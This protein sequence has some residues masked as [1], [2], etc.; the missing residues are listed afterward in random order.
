VVLDRFRSRVKDTE[1]ARCG[2]G[3][4]FPRR[5]GDQDRLQPLR[6]Q[7]RGLLENSL[8]PLQFDRRA[9]LS[10]AAPNGLVKNQDLKIAT[11][12][13]KAKK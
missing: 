5:P 9:K 4:K 3:S 12:C 2:P 13:K 10:F 6:R 7:K 1:L 8:N 11:S